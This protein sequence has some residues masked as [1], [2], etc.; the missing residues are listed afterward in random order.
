VSRRL[1][2]ALL[3]VAGCA[4]SGRQALTLRGPGFTREL[5]VAADGSV[6][7]AAFQLRAT[8]DGYAGTSPTGTVHLTVQGDRIIGT[9]G[10][11]LVDMHVRVEGGALRAQGLFAGEMSQLAAD[12][13]AVTASFGRCSYRL[14]AGGGRLEGHRTC[15]ATVPLQVISMAVP[16]GFAALP[17]ERRAMLLAL[18]FST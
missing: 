10:D 11:S 3:L 18:L 6:R 16:P 17:A 2:S 7:G 8:G 12:G 1:L 9:V 13:Q 15:H 4:A 14:H 5:D